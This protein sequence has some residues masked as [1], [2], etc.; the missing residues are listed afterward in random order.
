M[1]DIPLDKIKNRGVPTCIENLSIWTSRKLPDA[2]TASLK[3]LIGVATKK[4][5]RVMIYAPNM[6]SA[7]IR[8]KLPLVAAN[9]VIFSADNEVDNALCK[10]MDSGDC[11]TLAVMP[12]PSQT[13][14]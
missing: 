5:D 9:A 12:P 1:F 11:Q 14:V 4:Y 6:N 10:L 13:A 2:E 8:E 3:K 7:K